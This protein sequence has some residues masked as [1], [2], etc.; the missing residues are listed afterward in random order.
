MNIKK[1]FIVLLAA[2]IFILISC[3]AFAEMPDFSALTDEE[4]H[5]MIDGARNELKTR[6]LVA[7][8]KTVLLDA[9]GVQIYLTGNYRVYGE[10]NVYC[11]LEAVLVNNSDRDVGVSSDGASVNGWEVYSSGF[12]SASPGKKMKGTID[13]KISD[14]EIST[15]EEIEDIDLTLHLF[16]GSTYTTFYRGETI[17]MYFN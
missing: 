3:E 8:E 2:I 13:L 15:Y 9:E 12:G 1:V 5:E 7:G 10:D 16:D 6:E 4:L 14:A 17:T 11:E